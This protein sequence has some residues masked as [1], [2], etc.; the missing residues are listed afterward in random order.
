MPGT[1]LQTFPLTS[2]QKEL[3]LANAVLPEGHPG[4]Y[5]GCL[6]VLDGEPAPER[7]AASLHVLLRHVPLLTATLGYRSDE[8]LPDV[9][10][11]AFPAPDFR[12][13]DLAGEDDPAGR[14]GDFLA[15]FAEQPF[16][17]VGGQLCQFALLRLGKGRSWFLMRAFHLLCDGVSLVAHFN[18]LS[19]IYE[20]AGRG[21][22]FD[23]GEPCDW[24]TVCAADRAYAAS[25]GA[26]RDAAFW[27]AH[28]ERLPAARVFA[29]LPGRPDRLDGSGQIDVKL[30]PAAMASLDAQAA[31]HGAGKSTVLA[32]LHAAL[33]ARLHDRR[34]L[35]VQQPLSLGER[36][37]IRRMHGCRVAISPLIVELAE[38]DTLASLVR[39]LRRQTVALLRHGRTP[40]QS[41]WREAAPDPAQAAAQ[42]IVWDTNLNYFPLSP[43]G[44]DGDFRVAS[45]SNMV[46]RH[47]PTVFGVYAVEETTAA[48][49]RLHLS[50]VY[51]RNHFRREDVQAYGER[52][53]SLLAQLVADPELPVDRW[54][55]LLPRE[56]SQLAAWQEGERRPLAAAAIHELFDR[57]AAL[58][59]AAP[60]VVGMDG[61]A[62]PYQALRARSD[63]IA[64]WLL[65]QG[66]QAGEV[67]AVLARR[68]PAL[69][70][71]ILGIM[72]AGAVYLPV[73]PAYPPARQAHMLADSGARRL[74]ALTAADVD[75]AARA[76][77][78]PAALPLPADLPAASAL[79]A[80]AP[81]HPAYLI[82]TSGS[83]G[84]PKG[85]LVRHGGFVNMIQAQIAAFGVAAHDRVLQFASPSFDASL[86]EIFMALL[87]GG[88]LHPVSR[89]LIDA[90][91]ALREH[92][93][94]QGVSVATL[95][96]SYLALFRREVF[97]GLRVLITAGEAPIAEDARHY[98]G[99]LAYFN[100]YGPTEASVCATLVRLAPEGADEP[101]G[102]GRPLPNTAACILDSLGETVAPGLPGEL[103]LG[104]EG[105]AIGYLNRPELDAERFFLRADDAGRRW[106]RT[107]DRALWLPSGEILLLGRS[108]DQVKIRGHRIELGEVGAAL[109]RHPDVLQASVLAR[110]GKGGGMLLVAFLVVG[111]GRE[112]APA[113]LIEWLRGQLPDFALPA[114]CHVLD[115]LPTTPAGKVDRQAL[116]R[117]DEARARSGGERA[118]HGGRGPAADEAIRAHYEAVLGAAVD[119]P[120]ADFFTLGGDSLKAMALVRRLSLAYG[121]PLSMRDFLA[122]SS[123]AALTALVG[124]RTAA[125]AVAGA[126]DE[127][128]QLPLSQGQLQLWTLYCL[129]GPG[130]RYNMPLALDVEADA[131]LCERFVDA[132]VAAI[133]RQPACRCTVGGNI[134]APRL[135]VHAASGPA[136]ERHDLAADDGRQAAAILD[137]FIHRPFVLDER[138]PIRLAVLRL[139]A[140]RWRLAL[141][142]H[143]IV[144]DGE[145]LG[146][147]LR[148]ALARLRDPRAGGEPVAAGVLK[149]FVDAEQA[150]LHSPAAAA[151]LDFWQRRLTPLPARLD[152]LPAGTR[153][154]LKQGLG[155]TRRR[156]LPAAAAARLAELAG[157]GGT[158]LLG[159]FVGALGAFLRRRSGRN[160]VAV[161][162]PL[163]LRDAPECF[164]AAGY[165]VNTVVVRPPPGGS[166]RA[167]V[168]GAGEAL[169]AAV[170]HGRYPFHRLPAALNEVRDPARSPLVDVLAT[171]IDQAALLAD[172]ELPAG[173]S[174]SF[175]DV[176]LRAAKFDYGFVLVTRH[177]GT[178][179]LLL[180][181]DL[182]V[183]DGAQ[184]GAI[185]DDFVDFLG[186]RAQP[187]SGDEAAED[188][189]ATEDGRGAEYG[190]TAPS[191]GAEDGRAAP[192]AGAEAPLARAWREILGGPSP[193]AESNFFLG[194]GD[195]IKAI[196]MVGL[197]RRLGVERLQ[198]G[199]FFAT[200]TFGELS[201]RLAAPAP[202][203]ADA[204]AALAAGTPMPLL[205]LQREFIARHRQSW[206]R[207][208]MAL[209]LRLAATVDENRLRQAVAALPARHEAFRLKFAD[210]AGETLAGPCEAAWIELQQ[211]AGDADAACVAEAATRLFAALDPRTGRTFGA[212]LVRRGTD[213]LLLLGGHHFV[214]DAVSLDLLR[215]E[216]AWYCR[217]GQWPPT[218]EG[219]GFATWALRLA[220]AGFP[221]ADEVDAWRQ[222]CAAGG[223]PLAAARGEALP[224]AAQRQSRHVVVDGLG[225]LGGES[226]AAPLRDLLATLAAALHACGQAAPLFVTLEGHGRQPVLP[227]ID[228]SQSVG[229]FTAAFPLRL[230]PSADVPGTARELAERL[231]RL[232][233]GGLGYGFAALRDGEGLAHAPQIAF[234]Y[235]GR[236]LPAGE[237]GGDFVPLPELA[238]PDALP[239]LLPEDFTAAV[240]LDLL[241]YFDAAGSL[242]LG[243][244]FAPS[245]VDAGWVDG[246][247]QAWAAALR[248]ASSEAAAVRAA[249][250]RAC[251]VEAGEIVDVGR[252]DAAQAGMLF[253][254][255]LDAVGEAADGEANYTQQVDF[256]LRGELDPAHLA[257]AWRQVLARHESLRTLFPR[258]TDGDSEFARLVLREARTTVSFHDL[259]GLSGEQQAA[260]RDTLLAAQRRIAFDLAAGPLLHLQLFRFADD[261][262]EMSWCFHHLLMDGWCIG[263]LLRELFACLVAAA[264]GRAPALPPAP[265]LAAWRRWRAARDDPAQPMH[266]A[267]RD[268]WRGLLDGFA[269]PTPVAAAF[270]APAQ[271]SSG[272]REIEL[273][274]EAAASDRL[275]ARAAELSATLPHLLQALWGLLLGARHG[276]RR[277]LVFGLVSAGRP[278]EVAD[279]ERT[280]GLFI[281]TL[282]VRL[283]WSPG[284]SLADLVDAVRRQAAERAPHEFMHLADIQREWS[285]SADGRRGALFDHILVFEN[286]P[287]D[288]IVQAGAPR[289]VGVGGVEHHPYALA[290]SVVPGAELCFRF[291]ARAEG[292]ADGGLEALVAC[293]RRLL[294]TVVSGDE[295]GAY[296]ALVERIAAALPARGRAP[297]E[298]F[299]RTARAY[300]RD[301]TVDAVFRRLAARHPEQ[302]ACIGA[303]DDALSYR[304]LDRLSDRVARRLPGL[305]PGA[306]VALL[307]PRGPA[308]LV[309]VLG[310]LKAG[311]CYLPLDDKNPPQRLR[312]MLRLAG[313]RRLIH[314]GASLARAG[315][316]DLADVACLDYGQLL[317][318]DDGTEAD[319]DAAH[320]TADGRESAVAGGGERP[321]YVMFT[322]GSTGEPKGVVVPHRGVLRLVCNSDFWQLFP[323]ERVLQAAPLGFDASTLEIWGALLNGGTV[324]FIDDDRLLAA[325]G[326]RQR[327]EAGRVTQMW[328]TASLC[329]VLAEDDSAQFAPLRRLFTGGEALNPAVIGR[330]MAA[331]PALEIFNGY[332]PTENTTFTTVHRIVAEDLASASI[333][334]GRPIANTRVHIVDACG[335]LAGIGEWGEI[336]AAG[337]GLALGYAGRE[338]LT[339]AAFVELPALPGERVY[340]TGDIGRWRADGAIEFAGRRDGQIKMR[341]YRIELAEIE[342][343]LLRLPGVRQA[344]VVALGQGEARQLVGF[345]C[346]DG[347]APAE[348]RAGLAPVLPPYM[349]PERIE[350]VASLPLTAS[351]KADRMA[352]AGLAGQGGGVAPAEAPAGA[353]DG[354]GAAAAPPPATTLAA[355]EHRI[356]AVFAEVLGLP[357]VARQ[358]DFFALGG[359]SLKAMRLMARLRRALGV[360]VALREVMTHTTP[361]ALARHLGAR[362]RA[363]LPAGIERVGELADYPLSSG[364]E[365]LW[366]LQ[367]MH[368]DSTAYSVPFA[369]RLAAPVDAARLQA[370]LTLLEARHDALRLRMPL[371]ATQ[372]GPRQT[373]AAPGGL[374]LVEHDLRGRPD[375][376]AALAAAIDRELA[377]PFAFGAAAPLVRASLFR[378]PGA[379][380]EN[381][382]WGLLLLVFH[383]LICDGWSGEVFLREL[384]VAG[385][386]LAAGVAPSWP[387][388]PVR[389]VDYAVWQRR[390]L[391]QPECAAL[392]ARWLARLDALPEPLRLPLDKPRPALQSQRGDVVR[393]DFAPARH[394]ALR[395]RMAQFGGTPFRTLLTLVHVFLSRH[396]GQSDLIVGVPVAGRE[397]AELGDV[398]GFF[399]N[400]LPLRLALDPAL[401]F[402]DAVATVGRSLQEALDDQACPLEVLLDRLKV[403]RDLSR[404]PLFDVIVAFEGAEWNLPEADGAWPALRPWP[405]PH[406]QSKVDLSFY[407]RERAGDL[408][409]DVEYASDLFERASV[410]R[411]AERLLTLVDAVAADPRT[412][413]RA[414]ELLPAAERECV[415]EGFNRT[416]EALDLTPSIDALFR[417]QAA[418]RPDAVALHGSDGGRVDF[419]GLD[420]RVDALARR[421]LAAGV[422]PGRHVGV[423]CERSVELMTAIY[424][425]LR[426]GGVYVPFVPGLPLE[427]I[428]A[429]VEDLGDCLVLCAEAARPHFLSL[430]IETLAVDGGEPTDPAAAV[431]PPVPADAAAYVIF[432]S[433]STGRPKG[434][435]VEHRSVVNR[436]RWMQS[437]FPLSAADVIL[438][439]TP[440]SF[441]VSVWE[442]FWWSWY[443]ASLAQLAPGEERDP[444]AIVAA[445]ARHRA[446][447]MHF[448]PSMLTAFLDHLESHPA[449]VDALVSLRL[450]F[451]SGEALTPE[452]V[453]RFNRLL[454]ARHGS[455]LHNLYGPTEATV[456]VSWH[457]C[458]P[459]PAGG[460][461]LS[462]PIGR[463]IANT[464]F[465]ILD[466][467]GQPVPVGVTGELFISGVQVAR[468]Y[469]N[470][471]E[472]TAERFADDPFRPGWRMYRSG[473]LARW[474]PTGEVEY[475][476]RRDDQVKIRG[477]RIEL[478]EVEAAL[479][480]CPGVAQAIVRVG[481][482]GGMP[483]LEAFLLPLP[484]QTLA[485]DALRAR[486][487]E[488]VPDYM[489]PAAYFALASVPVNASGKADRKALQGVRLG[490]G[491]AAGEGGRDEGNGPPDEVRRTLLDI[492]S[493]LLPEAGPIGIDQNFFD[494]GGSSLLLLRLHEALEKH[495]P[496]R[497][498]LPEL[499]V[500]CS[501]RLQAERIAAESTASAA[502]P[503]AAPVA[504]GGPIAVVGMAL[505]LADY[506]DAESFWSDLLT[507][508]DRTTELSPAR[509]RELTAMLAAIGVDADPARFRRAA[510]L[511]DIS[512]FDCRRFGM[513][514]GDA[515]LLDPEQRLFL[516]TAL[517]ALED[518]GYG[519]RA[520]YGAKLGVFAGASPAQTFREAVGRS[521]PEAGEQAYI[522]NVPSNMATRLGYL[523]NWDGPAALVD[524]ACSSTL[525]AVADAVAALRRGECE[526]AVAG[527]ARVLLTPLRGDQAFSIET[528]SGRT[529]SFDAGAD[530]VGAGEGAVVF[531]LK[532]L[533][534]AQADG[535]AIRAVLLGAAVNQDGRSAGIAAPNPEAQA[536][537]IRAAAADAG[538]ALDSV[539]FFEAHGTGTALGDPIE[540]DGLT[541][542]FAG[543]G[544]ESGRTRPVPIGS[545]KGNFGHLDSAAGAIGLAKAVLA[546]QH[547][548]VPRQPHFERPNP[549]IDFAA[550]P[551]RVAGENAALAAADRPW[552]GGVS[553]FGLSGI[554]VHLI[555][556]QA[557]GAAWP[558]DDGAWHCLPLSAGSEQGL[559]R[560]VEALAQ[561]L[562]RRPDWPLHA[563]AA[564]LIGGRDH[565]EVRAA[566]VARDRR[567]LV[568]A[569]LAW[570]LGGAP[571]AR[572]PRPD[573]APPAVLAGGLADEAAARRAADAFMAG[574]EP[575]WP[576]DRPAWRAHL[577]TVPMERQ[578]CWPAFVARHAAAAPPWLGAAVETAE[579]WLFPVPAADPRFWPAAEHRLAGEPT[580]VGMAV[581]ALIA[582]A[583]AAIPEF[584]AGRPAM[585]QLNWL[586][587][588]HVAR[589]DPASLTLRLRR[590]EGAFAASLC[591]RL[592]A[593]GEDA[594][595][596]ADFAV[597][598]VRPAAD[599]APP[600]LD[601]DALRAGL[602]PLPSARGAEASPTVE[603]SARWD[604]RRRG[605]QSADG[606]ETLAWLVLPE[607]HAD[608]LRR[609]DWHP[610]LLD[611]GASLALDRPGLVPA[612]CA[613]IRLH[614]PLPGRLYAHARR[615]AST[616][617]D[618]RHGQAGALH[619]DCVFTDED[620]VVLAEFLGLV[621]VPLPM[622]QARLHR[623][624]WRQAPAAAAEPAPPADGP[625]LVLGEGALADALCAEI[626]QSGAVC[627]RAAVPADEAA[628]AALAADIVDA[629]VSLVLHRADDAATAGWPLAA[630]LQSICRRGLRRPLRWLAF[631]SGGAG[632][633]SS[634]PADTAG[635]PEAALALGLLLSLN[636]EEPLF[637]GRYVE[638]R[639]PLAAADLLAESRLAGPA[640]GLPVLLEALPAGA[641]GV[642]RCERA[643]SAPVAAA[644]PEIV[645]DAGAC[646]L[647]T[648]GLGGMALTLAEAIMPTLDRP[649][650][651]LHR[652]EF[653]PEAAWA[654]LAAGDDPLAAE[655]ATALRRLRA[656]GVPLH[657]YACDVGSREALAATLAR[658]RREV[659]PIGGVVHAAGVPGAGFLLGKSRQDFD[660]VLAPRL[661]ARHLHELTQDDPVRFFVLAAS[662]TALAGA[663]GQTDYTAANAFLDAFAWWRRAAGLPA[664]AIDWNAWERV[665]MAAR[666]GAVDAARANLPPEQAGAL[667]LRA[668]ASGATQLV[669]AMPGETLAAA[670]PLPVP[671]DAGEDAADLP[672][673]ERVLRTVAQELGY[674]RP[675]A[676]DDDFYALGGDS[677]TGLRIVN[678]LKSELRCQVGLAD[679][680]S[681]SRLAAFVEVIA[682]RLGG[683]GT[684]P[685][686]QGAPALDAYPVGIE[687]LAVLQAE[688][689]AA[690]HTGYNLPQFL[691]LPPD[692]DEMRLE[693]ALATLVARHEILRTR[694]IDVDTPTPRM[695]ILPTVDFQL[696]SHALE[697]LDE[698][699]VRR[700]VLPFRLDRA[701]LFRAALLHLPAGETLLFFDI[702][703]AV[704]DART[705]DIL[706]AELHAL[707][708]GSGELPPVPPLQ[709]KDA[710]W[711]QRRQDEG[712]EERAARDYWLARFAGPLP[713]L[714]L[715][716][717]RL[718][719]ARHTHRG[720]T[721]AFEVPADWLPAVRELARRQETTSYALMLALWAAVL[722]RAA[723]TE[724]LVVAVAVDGRDREEL[725][726]TTG[727]FASL[728]PLRLSPRAGES[729]AGLLRDS[730]RRH[731]EALR[732]RR[733]PL[734]RLLAALRPP[735]ALERTLL[736]EVS[737][738]YMNFDSVGPASG[739]FARVHAANPSCKGD[740]SIFGS[741]GGDRLGF[742]IEYY[743]DLFAPARIARLGEDFLALLG[744]VLAEGC[745]R[746]LAELFG[747]AR[748][749]P[750]A[751]AAVDAPPAAP[752]VPAPHAA[753]AALDAQVLLAYRQLFGNAAIGA[754]D[755]FFDLGGHSLLGLQIVNQLARQTG[756]ELSIRDLFDHPTPAALAA[757]IAA[758]AGG[759]RRI[760]R[761]P[762]AADGR[763]PLSHAQQ[764]LYVLHH[765]E[766]GAAAYNMPF[767][768]R[769]ATPLDEAALSRLRRAL[770]RLCERHESLRTAFVEADG[771]LWQAVGDVAPPEFTVEDLV[772]LGAAGPAQ[773]LAAF[774]EDAA[775]PF[776]LRQAPLLRLRVCR[777]ADGSALVALVMHH[778]VGDGWSMQIFFGE[779]LALYA[780]ESAELPP[781]AVQYRDYAVWQATRDWSE[782]RAYWLTQLRDAPA[783]IALPP[784]AAPAAPGQAAG[785]VV[786]TLPADLMADARR[787]ARCKGISLATLFL[788]LF[789]A[790]LYRLTRQRDLLL[791]MGVAGRERQEL[792]G[793]IGFFVNILPIRISMDDETELD[794]LIDRVH[795]TC[796]EA[797]ERQDYPFDLL[798]REVASGQG[799][800]RESLVNVMFEYQRYGDL[801]G[802][803][804]LDAQH[805]PLAASP[806]E[807]NEPG[808]DEG[809]RPGTPAK[810]DL[811]LFVQ[812]EPAACR[813]K[814]EF[815]PAAL[816]GRT[817]AG[818]LAY[819]EQFLRKATESV[820]QGE[821]T[822]P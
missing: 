120:E 486:M 296:D 414:L 336:C 648:G 426:A 649:A 199:D 438:Q 544:G 245:Q 539:D 663:A 166:L 322:S 474:L 768:F 533:A 588:L 330:I 484:G 558:A 8:T 225:G 738:S 553:A 60:A 25:A 717:D 233:D 783:R 305:A 226:P 246:L 524:T 620:G 530:G 748:P 666:L 732:H 650:V 489:C 393:V 787:L 73:D 96:P 215:Q 401:P 728:L 340:R 682:G 775:R 341:G 137:E 61:Q 176:A 342:T 656:Q 377:Q 625:R 402:A 802:I 522:L 251:G 801:Q 188:D 309:A 22:P 34:I 256:R 391:A 407:F 255:L 505:R 420:R 646:V 327:I 203:A 734:N 485:A 737:F 395:A 122:G 779:W 743:A 224:G 611:V 437:R 297:A 248:A 114:R 117:L 596:W 599:A 617:A 242:R 314:D 799:R 381:D 295:A 572:P 761:Q 517:R 348:I 429:M 593:D 692:F 31:R 457:P 49:D 53:E 448:V 362:D 466:A 555:L 566:F 54:R 253:Q 488:I 88:S 750:A 208:H 573:G 72:K 756:R 537:V 532:P 478:G 689:V 651:L 701:P 152:L 482:V 76:G 218:R 184:A 5:S 145:S 776:D 777:L 814:A 207:F 595:T 543:A 796:L 62:Q 273:R 128:R 347:V 59:P 106:Y 769:V 227:G 661:A 425:V 346:A 567:Q 772:A 630:L 85:V 662:R 370:A 213:R 529:R 167:D 171:H 269:G 280:V 367:R 326:L 642:R 307:V 98:A 181:H 583:C 496:G 324:C 415:V 481:A 195:S 781:L 458:S 492:W 356:A 66:V 711:L 451:A 731:A 477:F 421:L 403:T 708:V 155:E 759:L 640:D 211:P 193:T 55:V 491:A 70:E 90:P 584:A 350:C 523:K 26:Q 635:R 512:G 619:A 338:D 315:L 433:G 399:V 222:V 494:I 605:W 270:D 13:V 366:F 396:S 536:K 520:L 766:G 815:D 192:G 697:R 422:S 800:P 182:A 788:T 771:Q 467:A 344:A 764:R 201:A 757:F 719:P 618:P 518:A 320:G 42:A 206:T 351:G 406:R 57:Q 442:L 741:D 657:L 751:A 608:D 156:R 423:C 252:P 132:L 75:A 687:Q 212:C 629:G 357:S 400:T 462:V 416:D 355:L 190:G 676:L 767:V 409:L 628:S 302:I 735:V 778:I 570:R 736:S 404:N 813:L 441:D 14:A 507:G 460:P 79:P 464:R 546:L 805:G 803:N 339:R 353:G 107:G 789:L 822:S 210:D 89:E 465:Y 417:Q 550:A 725:A 262:H 521:F 559:R 564:S 446:S 56:A 173:L 623:V 220:A 87:A 703:H 408:S 127:V 101:I 388:L 37:D 724:D 110:P 548:R 436:L 720:G 705:V 373:V 816:G 547:G 38:G 375:A 671:T 626:E 11:G 140:R 130:A 585:A 592:R 40:F 528:A 412:P 609:T 10:T 331:C 471:P 699:A 525:K 563:V 163:G 819:L 511:D 84:L 36:K 510:Y 198:P 568:D 278:A 337:D 454:H 374:C 581:P 773:A 229:W 669:V 424:A 455:E 392:C 475:L 431:L 164:A 136:I 580:L 660:A 745:E 139:A 349:L 236:L 653:P 509:R 230:T 675:P 551:V 700:L 282:P 179:E 760:V 447:V 202:Q 189:D 94:A 180:E 168:R 516:E 622:P 679:L 645:L 514:P 744:R 746:R 504:E 113:P 204:S 1:P 636:R 590:Q 587:P 688:A 658:V 597:A 740:L 298:A 343:A 556:E 23:T 419:A 332:G 473:D 263:I 123:L 51:S 698:A 234:N 334:I 685:P 275:R 821:E 228:L 257:R 638:L 674:E 747:D 670:A 696:A 58:T 303:D 387:P 545:V 655:R 279:I 616:E 716:A 205:P 277:D 632:G 817:V 450:V 44:G 459:L 694:F 607:A 50:I 16:Q 594:G 723:G 804:R 378:M 668:L 165:F 316:A 411:M 261:E 683:E 264:R 308:A 508:S 33:L 643:L 384:G 382:E 615:R 785:V 6:F 68:H 159:A 810:Y 739:G 217:E 782:E 444:A 274:L 237:A 390:F 807:I 12:F 515:R 276:G 561:A 169:R 647:F 709:Q 499:F 652:G 428:R 714:D 361:A 690:P 45:F 667:L 579:G 418:H 794:A 258:A 95:P 46:S 47:E 453:V 380:A 231:A 715:P 328:L 538:V 371:S 250:A 260:R 294:E 321:A 569:L 604:C 576:G 27:A 291:N 219:T 691:R 641:P 71:S 818:W 43:D 150:Y 385:R 721:A 742:A 32:A 634:A 793:L 67:V 335:A 582:A 115:A 439:K 325:G 535:D 498:S 693:A 134:D 644:A 372:D 7:V 552:R 476:G 575:R 639:G 519:G 102:I 300:P 329:G 161:A 223:A 3:W 722:G 99:Q 758:A 752:S 612:A 413:L 281:Q 808:A 178:C 797:L 502:P 820:A 240:P 792:E 74:L 310:I 726:R 333:P 586:R 365:R 160:D 352:L 633:E 786:R 52:L 232:T 614:R 718:R 41:G 81:E 304:R 664:L 125:G 93:A 686:P 299:N 135:T 560:Y 463:P 358:A 627:R 571:C 142:L 147:L 153:R 268:Y 483:A 285:A 69:A 678:R 762:A 306:P 157:Q 265:S 312:D 359:Q 119:D 774:R 29:P 706:L 702:H 468:G 129:N 141:V 704:A 133:E 631:G 557:P 806:V 21:E 500:S 562:A 65:E 602:A 354:A 116:L 118:S 318:D 151:D 461:L 131:G 472:L 405:L 727:M 317:A 28:L 578:T 243:A 621:F 244:A 311:G 394:A 379:D 603:V 577:P 360:D 91:W 292:F 144:G 149:R 200:P 795:R 753:D 541:R 24:A 2:F 435:V 755:S 92:M 613:D 126:D 526:L 48:G 784:E 598:V 456:D 289:I 574:A 154:P 452:A 527:G 112:S 707:C 287:V 798:V 191:G 493:T 389:Y 606:L 196:Q 177:D 19:R 143:H 197:L 733:F 680:F 108:D 506:E 345:V 601:L 565:L 542:A 20:S 284:A 290:V 174:L 283:G 238:A 111:G 288:G 749:L 434:V 121:L 109:E 4:I 770:T 83:T 487:R 323:G 100:A 235:L 469:V 386:A 710:A 104:G 397:H 398:L 209:P 610:A 103:C 146:L 319:A 214:L 9:E 812:D 183:A 216:L 249:L 105:L 503:A 427:R 654:A 712:A 187:S 35:S 170:A 247:L 369:A 513:A 430:G 221:P 364:Q 591:G 677:I 763:Y 368:A 301:D 39:S 672:L 501:V 175:A 443:G 15:A 64:G 410:E 239:G 780:D 479:Q 138:P 162:V 480:R 791:G 637:H 77:L 185:L 470:R 63:A 271:A 383:H 713:R 673:A 495:W 600:R 97:P 449:A 497:F 172:A 30:S 695:R 18:L 730:H 729:F 363:G 490:A 432:T 589:V 659:G 534:R 624:E 241:A 554:N 148:D 445:V 440:I 158:T 754:G 313:C 17:P 78:S 124:R 194:G 684:E 82:Y 549:K 376:A 286:Y 293:W 811:T 665:G 259:S 809:G 186:A 86:S 681:H 790:L 272:R 254:H 540:I 266:R 80:V 765:T 267:A 531:L